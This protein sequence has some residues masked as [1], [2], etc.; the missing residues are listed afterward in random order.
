MSNAVER[1]PLEYYLGLKYPVTIEESPEGGFVA[2][3]DDLPGCMT[4]GETP[5][6][7]FENIEEARKLWLEATYEDGQDIPLP[8]TEKPYSGK[9]IL[10]MPRSL[11]SLL[12]RRAQIE[13]V[14]L[15]H[16]MVTVLAKAVGHDQG[17]AECR[18]PRT[19]SEASDW[20]KA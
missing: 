9:M 14:S 4:Q 19:F 2:A 5:D 10:R 15:N 17:L 3:I 18:E 8:K 16:Y 1:R 6:E 13:G 12:D 11:H 20:R 7:V